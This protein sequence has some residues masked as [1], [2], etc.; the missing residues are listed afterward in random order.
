MHPEFP[1]SWPV[2]QPRATCVYCRPLKIFNVA[3]RL[4]TESV[5]GEVV[6]SYQSG[7]MQP[8]RHGLM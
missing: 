3:S 8:E 2:R 7:I 6:M 5:Q 4:M 1:G